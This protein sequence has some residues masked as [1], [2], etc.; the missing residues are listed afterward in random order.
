MNVLQKFTK[1]TFQVATRV[2][3]GSE[4]FF[5]YFLSYMH[6]RMVLWAVATS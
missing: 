3:K 4:D 6:V 1:P 5:S 2:I